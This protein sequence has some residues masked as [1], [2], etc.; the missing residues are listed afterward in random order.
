GKVGIVEEVGK[1]VVDV[2]V[3]HVDRDGPQLVRREHRL[4]V[5]GVVEEVH[6]D[7]VAG[8]DPKGREPVREPI[9][10]RIELGKGPARAPGDERDP[11]RHGVGHGLEQVRDVPLHA[12]TLHSDPMADRSALP[13]SWL[14]R[15][16]GFVPK[17]RYLDPEFLALELD[18]MWSRVWQIAC[19]EEELAE[20][21]DYV[22]YDIG[23]QSMIV[24]RDPHGE[25]HAFHNVCLHRGTR[26][27]DGPGHLGDEGTFRCPFHAWRYAPDGRWVEVVDAEDF[28]ALPAALLIEPV[29]VATWGGFVFVNFD[30]GAEPLLEYLGP[31]P[32]LL[33]PYHL[34][35]MRLRSVISTV[36]PA[37]W[38]ALV[39]AFNEAYHVQ[40][41]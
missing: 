2:A 4:E 17:A 19:R 28:P 10:A 32:A 14:T 23:D 39:D 25:I 34:E 24:A 35:Q 6:T 11:L 8:P 5:L 15:D 9:R 37:N 13:S 41:A 18:H 31:L 33:A 38:K 16:D 26:L 1:L 22:A 29:L 36:L 12:L 27:A 7:V 21:G 20:P 40:G 3:V 30:P